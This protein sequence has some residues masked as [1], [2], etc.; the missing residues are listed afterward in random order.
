MF[1][2]GLFLLFDAI[3]A[4]VVPNFAPSPSY[5]VKTV[6]LDAGHGGHVRPGAWAAVSV[7]VNNDGPAITGAELRVR[8]QQQ[9][10]S[11]FGVVV[12]LANDA[13]QRHFV[14][15]Q[16]PVFGTRLIV[17]LVSGDSVLA[18]QEVAIK[19][20]DI[21]TPIV[22]V[23]AERPEGFTRDEAESEPPEAPRAL[24]PT[25]GGWLVLDLRHLS[26]MDSTGVRLILQA[27]EAADMDSGSRRASEPRIC[28]T[29]TLSASPASRWSRVSPTQTM[30]LIP[31]A[32]TA[33][34]F[35]VLH[36]RMTEQS[37]RSSRRNRVGSGKI[38]SESSRFLRRFGNLSPSLVSRPKSP[39]N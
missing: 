5:R 22:A 31:A 26:F 19:S 7:N 8:S 28:D 1:A 32:A 30:G 25:R 13:R 38:A 34:A 33:P 39:S 3:A 37:V 4:P 36:G 35:S 6:V 14:Y 23:V 16:P 11:R 18:S 17:E 10:V 12:D 20:H 21:Y 29:T 24:Q 15:V 9:G 27:M 2:L